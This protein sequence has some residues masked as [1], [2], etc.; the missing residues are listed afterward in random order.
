MATGPASRCFPRGAPRG[1]EHHSDPE[2][3][4]AREPPETIC[5][6]TCSLCRRLPGTVAAS[7]K[8]VVSRLTDSMVQCSMSIYREWFGEMVTD[9]RCQRSGVSESLSLTLLPPLG[10]VRPPEHVQQTDLAATLAVGLGLPIPQHSVG[11]FL[12]PVVQGRALREQLRLL[13][14]NA[15]QLSRLL[16]ARIPGFERGES[17]PPL[18]R[19]GPRVP[20]PSLRPGC[21]SE[22]GH[23]R[24]QHPEAVVSGMCSQTC[25]QSRSGDSSH[26]FCLDSRARAALVERSL[27]GSRRWPWGQVVCGWRGL[28]GTCLTCRDEGAGVAGAEEGTG[29]EARGVGASGT[30]ARV[31]ALAFVLSRGV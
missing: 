20:W 10:E 17:R 23:H 28:G 25:A 29:R 16:R 26:C 6:A 12:F 31:G 5:C 8:V 24:E 4:A 30:L 15:V 22:L 9:V 3:G 19:L 7:G 11:H 14:L 18:V 27:R 2:G 21:A 13:H 1:C